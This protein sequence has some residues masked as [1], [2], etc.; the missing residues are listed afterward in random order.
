MVKQPSRL[1]P[2]HKTDK[3]PFIYYPEW[4]KPTL[5]RIKQEKQ[6]NNGISKQSCRIS[7]SHVVGIMIFVP[8]MG[9]Y[10][11]LASRCLTSCCYRR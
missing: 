4:P 3:T 8:V 1:L 10:L 6:V 9:I 5:Q 2:K 11:G 7:K